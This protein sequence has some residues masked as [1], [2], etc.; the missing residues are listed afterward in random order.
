MLESWTE[1]ETEVRKL[2]LLN[3]EYC[4]GRIRSSH[5]QHERM[6]HW[7]FIKFALF[8]EG[9]IPTTDLRKQVHAHQLPSRTQTIEEILD[10]LEKLSV[11]KGWPLDWFIASEAPA[12]D[13][14]DFEEK[15]SGKTVHSDVRDGVLYAIVSPFKTAE[16]GTI[17]L[18]LVRPGEVD[19]GPHKPLLAVDQP[20]KIRKVKLPSASRKQFNEIA[21]QI[22]YQENGSTLG[23]VGFYYPKN[24]GSANDLQS[25]YASRM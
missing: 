18:V 20:D 14:R 13:I 4:L 23:T 15:H 25:L 2:D 6:V 12:P 24:E 17:L 21:R 9:L 19:I 3:L 8:L 11:R 16:R 22:I 7:D 1:V 10:E 5:N